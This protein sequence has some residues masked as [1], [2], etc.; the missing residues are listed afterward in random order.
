MTCVS[1]LAPVDE[2][3][4][5]MP[6]VDWIICVWRR[7]SPNKALK[8]DGKHETHLSSVLFL[9]AKLFFSFTRNKFFCC[10]AKYRL[11]IN[12]FTEWIKMILLRIYIAPPSSSGCSRVGDDEKKHFRRRKKIK[13]HSQDRW[14]FHENINEPRATYSTERSVNKN[15]PIKRN[16]DRWLW[17]RKAWMNTWMHHVVASH[18]SAW[19]N[20]N[21]L[22]LNEKKNPSRALD[23]KLI[24]YL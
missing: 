19:S 4:E 5:E 20:W 6:F 2:S 24:H 15:K 1:N 16:W 18:I 17:E 12:L 13:I 22:D 9:R 3:K 23:M 11:M 10:A 8:L 21:N 7:H 14:T